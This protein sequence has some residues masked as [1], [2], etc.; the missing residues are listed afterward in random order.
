MKINFHLN[1]I[2]SPSF[3][4]LFSFIS[5]SIGLM[6]NESRVKFFGR[7]ALSRCSHQ[8]RIPFFN[9]SDTTN[10]TRRTLRLFRNDFGI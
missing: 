9:F 7:K 6:D 8:I 4:K 10:T 3:V 5:N 2:K 1:Y